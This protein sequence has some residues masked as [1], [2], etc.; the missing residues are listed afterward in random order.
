MSRLQTSHAVLVRLLEI[1]PE[2]IEARF[3]HQE[4]GPSARRCIVWLAFRQY[5][6]TAVLSAPDDD[7]LPVGLSHPEPIYWSSPHPLTGLVSVRRLLSPTVRIRLSPFGLF[8]VG[9]TKQ[10]FPP[11]AAE[12]D[13][14]PAYLHDL[15]IGIHYGAHKLIDIVQPVVNEAALPQ[16]RLRRIR[17]IRNDLEARWRRA[18][19]RFSTAVTAH[20]LHTVEGLAPKDINDLATVLKHL[21]V[22][23][24]LNPRDP[25]EEDLIL[26]DH[27]EVLASALPLRL[28]KLM[29]TAKAKT[30]ATRQPVPK[31]LEAKIEAALKQDPLVSK[32]VLARRFDVAEGTIGRNPAWR[33]ARPA[34]KKAQKSEVRERLTE[35]QRVRD[36]QRSRRSDAQ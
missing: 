19:E 33:S 2:G 1:A 20:V 12:R 6:E 31:D 21:A 18:V 11:E 27:V 28:H 24:R 22:L 30:K 32:R 8:A 10:R 13:E 36:V 23:R 4:L 5:V 26:L 16:H 35:G 29:P 25:A 9:D 3:L 14:V 17:F 7:M 34:A 15:L